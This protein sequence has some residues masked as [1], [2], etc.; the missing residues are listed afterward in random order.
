MVGLIDEIGKGVARIKLRLLCKG[1]GKESAG[2]GRK[3]SISEKQRSHVRPARQAG[4][5]PL[6][7]ASHHSLGASPLYGKNAEEVWGK[8]DGI[9]RLR[10]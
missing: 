9:S 1:C 7:H 4:S 8:G 10:R 3:I 2:A 5:S 6:L